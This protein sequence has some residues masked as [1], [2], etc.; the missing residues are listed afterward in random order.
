MFSCEHFSDLV[1]THILPKDGGAPRVDF[2]KLV[3][4]HGSTMQVIV[5][6][7]AA[8]GWSRE[9]PVVLDLSPHDPSLKESVWEVTS[10]CVTGGGTGH[11]K[12]DVYPDG[13]RV[14]AKRLDKPGQEVM[15]FQT[16][17]FIGMR[18]PEDIVL[19]RTNPVSLSEVCE[20]DLRQLRNC[21]NSGA[22]STEK[23]AWAD[24]VITRLE[25]HLGYK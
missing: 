21:I 20:E 7:T 10:T 23:R 25:K 15:F 9:Y 16:G 19:T 1:G 18:P 4:T 6:E 22:L 17:C 8:D 14:T 13:H 24:K 11:G 5:R 12:Y 2:S 3:F